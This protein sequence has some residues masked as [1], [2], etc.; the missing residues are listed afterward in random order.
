[1]GLLDYLNVSLCQKGTVCLTGLGELESSGP[2]QSHFH[3]H[4]APGFLGGALV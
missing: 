4:I 2:F 1:M 3:E